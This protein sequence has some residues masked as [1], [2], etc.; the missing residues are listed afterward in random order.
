MARKSRAFLVLVK[1]K[2]TKSPTFWNADLVRKS[3]A[4][5]TFAMK[6]AQLF[7]KR[8]KKSPTF[9]EADL[10]R[11]SRAFRNF[12]MKK[13]QLFG[14]RRKKSPTFWD[15]DLVRK[16]RAFMLCVFA[17]KSRA[18]ML[19]ISYLIFHNYFF[20]KDF[21]KKRFPSFKTPQLNFRD[22]IFYF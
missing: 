22:C 16:S 3:R 2:K 6:K 18:F 12:A 7:E 14:K 11:K 1:C 19:C 10:G 13:A 17:L 9:W 21:F 8:R 20:L 4:F 5:G 15:A